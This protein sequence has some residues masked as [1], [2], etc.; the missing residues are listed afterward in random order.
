MDIVICGAGTV[1]SYAADVLGSAGHNI[2]VID[3][4]ADRL[5]EIEETMDVRTLQGN[6]TYADV[7]IKAGA[8]ACDL[9]VAATES[10][11]INLLSAAVGKGVGAAKTIA[12]VRHSAYFDAQALDYARDARAYADGAAGAHGA[13]GTDGEGTGA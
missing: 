4:Q 1:G 12:R 6:C 8:D 11:E 3:L 5:S 10:D 13:R 9:L 2:T 7:L